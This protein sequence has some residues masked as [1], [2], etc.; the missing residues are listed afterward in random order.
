MQETISNWGIGINLGNSLDAI[1]GETAWNN[2]PTTREMIHMFA[3]AGFDM[4]RI[5]VTWAGHFGP[6]PAF[7]VDPAWMDR[8]QQVVDWAL[9][10]GLRVIL[11]T[12]HEQHVWMPVELKALRETIPP[13]AALW[14]QIA[15]RFAG[16]DDMLVFQG[17]NEPRLE[18]DVDEWN[19]ATPDVRAAV[20]ALNAT[21]VDVVRHSGGNNAHRWLCIPTAGA[22]ITTPGLKDLIIP[23]DDRLIVT[24]H[25]YK[26]QA[27]G[28]QNDITGSTPYFGAEGEAVLDEAFA[29]LKAFRADHPTVPVMVTEHGAVSKVIGPNDERNDADRIRYEKAFLSRAAA[30]GIPCIYWDN[31]YYS[32]GDEWFGLFDREKLKCNTPKML[33]AMLDYRAKK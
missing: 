26:P 18:N 6:A 15:E 20:N 25:S 12:H 1:G 28:L 11:N 33:E 2:P 9:E 24:V 4:L 23:R 5:P 10:E 29:M 7:A 32:A 8:V 27:F 13:F 16:Y 17:M 19:G 3:Q 21:F 14:K 31:N 22:Q 30:L